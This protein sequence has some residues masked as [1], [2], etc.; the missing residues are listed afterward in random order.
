MGS[1]RAPRGR[2]T[3]PSAPPRPG[4]VSAIVTAI[5][6]ATALLVGA[7][8]AGSATPVA[9]HSGLAAASPGPGSVV[10]GEITEA[11]LLYESIVVEARGSVSD[12]SGAELGSEVELVSEVEVRIVLDE[13]LTVPGEHAVRHTVRSADGDVVE[14]AYLFTYE[15]GAPPP[16]LEFVD[17]D[18]GAWWWPTVVV[19]AV[20]VAVIGV[21]AARL[22]AATRRRAAGDVRDGDPTVS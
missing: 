4:A 21:L 11:R 6:T 3:G 12:P 16:L 22:I 10:G 18:D 1:R 9:A 2:V 14:A 8:L 7:T 17:S 20:G 19:A 15:P 5:V 13:A